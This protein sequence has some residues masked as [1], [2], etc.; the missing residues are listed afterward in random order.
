MTTKT[1]GLSIFF[2]CTLL[3]LISL[4]FFFSHHKIQRLPSSTPYKRDNGGR[5]SRHED[6]RS[7]FCKNAICTPTTSFLSKAGE[8]CS[9]DFHCYSQRCRLYRAPYFPNRAFGRCEGSQGHPASNNLPC[10]MNS[11]C[12]SENCSSSSMFHCAASVKHRGN[13]NDLCDYDSQCKDNLICKLDQNN[14]WKICSP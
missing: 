2:V 14:Q 11:D 4:Y 10:R 1:K 13:E 7:H 12:L 8:W 3:T 9:K 5:C 6:C